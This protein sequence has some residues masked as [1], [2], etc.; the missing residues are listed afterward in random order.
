MSSLLD[1]LTA[2]PI[3]TALSTTL[4]HLHKGKTLQEAVRLGSES[5]LGLAIDVWKLLGYAAADLGI[6]YRK[7]TKEWEDLPRWQLDQLVKQAM[8]RLEPPEARRPALLPTRSTSSPRPKG[9]VRSR[10]GAL[11]EL[12]RRHRKEAGFAQPTAEV[13]RAL[14]TRYAAEYARLV[15]GNS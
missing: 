6:S 15:A 14:R 10:S 8:R 13:M 1:P 2:L 12:W 7:S 5:K 4:D 9:D 11:V 3:Q